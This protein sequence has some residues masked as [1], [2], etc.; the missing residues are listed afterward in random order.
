MFS[1]IF[2]IINNTNNNT[3]CYFQLLFNKYNVLYEF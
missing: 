3:M 1:E 2:K